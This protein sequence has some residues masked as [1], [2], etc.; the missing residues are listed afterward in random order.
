MLDDT[1]IHQAAVSQKLDLVPIEVT[2][3]DGTPAII[4]PLFPGSEIPDSLLF[5]IHQT[6]NKEIEMGETYPIERLVSL[7]ECTTFW[8]GAF[9]AVMTTGRL[10]AKF[11]GCFFIKPNYPGRCSHVA[12]SGFLVA[13]AHRN[14]GIGK[15]LAKAFLKYCPQLGY[16]SC[17]FNLVFATNKSSIRLW[18]SL[19]FEKIGTVKNAARLKGHQGLTN[20]FI[21]GYQ[22]EEQ[23]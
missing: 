22:F 19:G 23:T 2:L 9:C 11:L 17:V 15:E 20:A 7:E 21:Y 6:L 8:F 5:S 10:D 3:R 13:H 12:N 16:K 14:Q 1:D 18:E 4:H